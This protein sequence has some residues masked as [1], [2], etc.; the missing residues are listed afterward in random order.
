[1]VVMNITLTCWSKSAQVYAEF[2]REVL[3]PIPG[4]KRSGVEGG[5]PPMRPM[6]QGNWGGAFPRASW[7]SRLDVSQALFREKFPV[8]DDSLYN[9]AHATNGGGVGHEHGHVRLN[10][11]EYLESDHEP[12]FN[13]ATP[14]SDNKCIVL[15][16]FCPSHR[17]ISIWFHTGYKRK[18][19]SEVVIHLVPMAHIHAHTLLLL[20][21][22]I[23]Y[24]LWWL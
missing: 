18:S 5:G 21:L 4:C 8:A 20:L 22:L 2:Y 19:N 23:V 11:F 15:I 13:T 6:P 24:Y 16:W 17:L 14:S 12:P 7:H 9:R 10:V 3:R 1:M